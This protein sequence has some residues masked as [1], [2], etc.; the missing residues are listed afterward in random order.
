MTLKEFIDAVKAAWTL[1][2]LAILGGIPIFIFIYILK[3]MGD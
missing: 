2:A 3:S 1:S